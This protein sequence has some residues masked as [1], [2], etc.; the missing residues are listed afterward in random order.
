ME[1]SLEGQFAP[2]S[3]IDV[4]SLTCSA[5]Y[6]SALFWSELPSF[7]DIICRDVCLISEIMEVGWEYICKAQ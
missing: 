3:K 4:F 6:Q 2:K 1:P 7:G 5:I